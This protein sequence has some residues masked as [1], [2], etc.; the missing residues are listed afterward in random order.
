LWRITVLGLF[1][2]ATVAAVYRRGTSRAYWLGFVTAGF[3]FAHTP[4]LGGICE[5]VHESLRHTL[6]DVYRQQAVQR[7][8][9]SL[10]HG[11]GGDPNPQTNMARITVEMLGNLDRSLQ[12]NLYCLSTLIAALLGGVIWMRMCATQPRDSRNGHNRDE[13]VGQ[14]WTL[15]ESDLAG[16]G[17][18]PVSAGRAK[19]T[20]LA[21]LSFALLALASLIWPRAIVADLW[22]VVT[23]GF[24]V[25]AL[26]AAMYRSGSV[27][28]FW[29]G[30]AVFGWLYVQST[31][32]LGFPFDMKE[33]ANMA[34]KDALLCGLDEVYERQAVRS[35]E[36]NIFSGAVRP[37]SPDPQKNLANVT[38]SELGTIIRLL[39]ETTHWLFALVFAMIGGSLG[40]R[41]YLTRPLLVRDQFNR[42]EHEGAHGHALP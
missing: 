12:F 6:D 38:S 22:S 39:D 35:A 10:R 37:T 26:P 8:E 15:K 42:D 17:S 11:W 40:K 36:S 23:F 31:L 24:I 30:V 4:G 20:N 7:G 27:R 28:A 34:V 9:W 1:A 16:N 25:F 19:W 13:E 3:L 33:A 41:L 18:P 32:V 2:F 5:V 29:V 14:G 21:L